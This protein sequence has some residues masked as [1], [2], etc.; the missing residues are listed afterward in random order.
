M[1][2]AFMP[3]IY[4]TITI[5]AHIV[6]GGIGAFILCPL[7]IL[8]KKGSKLHRN[9]GR[10]YVINVTLICLSGMLTLADPA[11]L[12]EYWQQESVVKGF[13]EIFQA[14]RNPTMFFF[15]LVV[16][17]AYMSFSAV[18]LWPRIGYGARDRI[19]SNAFD[20]LLAAVMGSYSVGFLIVGI[21][22]LLSHS[23]YA[24]TFLGGSIV[25]MGFVCFDVYT[26][27]AR[28]QV[29]RYP[30][31]A[32]HMT[33]LFYAWAGLLDAFWIRLR[34]FVLPADMLQEPLPLGTILWLGLTVA[35]F[36]L[37]RKASQREAS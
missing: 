35:G 10:L 22:D 5:S 8:A 29:S 14:S 2:D 37:F 15:F 12:G 13:S 18:R 20:W 6:L 32:L 36:L 26:F 19:R 27:I 23:R 11:F 24:T 3:D 1:T 34:V 31:W 28:P 16:M 9:A 25:M 21:E 7:A 33:K 30:W 4:M 17:L